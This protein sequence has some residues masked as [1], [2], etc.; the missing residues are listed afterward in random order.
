MTG[1]QRFGIM[2]L[3]YFAVMVLFPDYDAAGFYFAGITLTMWTGVIL[4]LAVI[5]NILGLY[6]FPNFCRFITLVFV[7]AVLFSLL[8]Y[9]PQKDNVTPIN[10]LKYGEFPTM[11]DIERGINRFTFNFDFVRRRAT[12]PENFIN[13]ELDENKEKIEETNDAIK[14]AAQKAKKQ[15]AKKIEQTLEIEVE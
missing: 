7:A 12:R 14:E 6:N 10:K 8:W 5:T 11:Q 3:C 2:L 9:F 4:I 13:Q 1:W 15:A